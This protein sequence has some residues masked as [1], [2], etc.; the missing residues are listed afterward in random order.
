MLYEGDQDGLREMYI[1]S[2]NTHIKY[3]MKWGYPTHVLGRDLVPVE[4]KGGYF[5]KPA[6]LLNIILTEMAKPP[7][8][9]NRAEWVV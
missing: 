1:R 5:N 7:G 4:G 3:G 8:D 6:W 2:V 9:A